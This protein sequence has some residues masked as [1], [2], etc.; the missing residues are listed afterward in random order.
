MRTWYPSV[1]LVGSS[2]LTSACTTVSSTGDD[3]S[4]ISPDVLTDATSGID[5]EIAVVDTSPE[6]DADP[7]DTGTV[8]DSSGRFAVATSYYDNQRTGANLRE[9]SLTTANVTVGRFG[10]LFSRAVQGQ[11][12]AQPL[13]VSGVDMPGHGTRNVVVVATEHNNVYAF[14]ADDPT[15]ATPYWSVN[16]GPTVPNTDIGDTS[17]CID[18]QPE[19]GISA[20]PVIDLA[21][22]TVYVEAKTKEGTQYIHRLHALDL[23]TGR[24]I[25]GGP[26]VITGQVLG[27][28]D[29]SVSGMLTF[30]PMRQHGRPGL[31]LDHGVIYMAFGSHCDVVPYHGWVFAYD[32]TTLRQRGV[33][34]DTPNG[35]SGGIWMSGAGMSADS[36]GDVYFVSGN[37]SFD[38]TA[39]PPNMSNAVSRMRLTDSG[40][41]LVDWFVPYNQML[42]N[43]GDLDLGT[44]T[45]M[46]IPGTN[47]LL[48]GGKEGQLYVIDRDHMGQY[49]AGGNDSQIV[50]RVLATHNMYYSHIHGSPVYWRGPTNAYIYVMGEEDVLR[51]Y[52]VLTNGLDPTCAMTSTVRAADGMPGGMLAVSANG[53]AAGSGIVWVNRPLQGDANIEIA[54]G[55]L[56]AFDASDLSHELW[57]SEQDP[58]GADRLGFFAKFAPPTVANG[59]VYVGTFSDRLQVYGLR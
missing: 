52:R 24:E 32:A 50:Q 29:D 43:D 6:P 8:V 12:Y 11:M 55:I 15:A 28:G 10:L 27:S 30:N 46:H 59:R 18:L 42:L 22:N 37:G 48:N 33:Y 39:S 4:L 19:I 3:G 34:V 38:L 23:A 45:V 31:L 58:S 9:T 44:T 20:T 14:D 49:V 2:L 35:A 5:A 26:V 41:Q 47:L 53:D 56:H 40:F 25:L 13:Y 21:T 17:P 57:N 16:L 7:P 1:I 36:M 54:V 51:A